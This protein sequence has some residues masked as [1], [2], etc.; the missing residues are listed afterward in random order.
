MEFIEFIGKNVPSSKNAKQITKQHKIIPSKLTNSYIKWIEPLMKNNSLKWF[1]MV[2]NE[3][4]PYVIGY[5]FYRDSRRHWDFNNIT[6][7]INDIFQQ[8]GYIED[9]DTKHLIPIYLGEELTDK[10]HSGFK[11]TIID[12]EK[13]NNLLK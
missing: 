13:Y 7:T 12:K 9:D 11:V 5:Y 6:Q 4:Y 2:Q 1:Q 10:K 3:V 8:H